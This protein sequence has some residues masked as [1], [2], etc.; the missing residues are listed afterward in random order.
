MATGRDTLRQ[1]AQFNPAA[2]TYTVHNSHVHCE[3]LLL[4]YLLLNPEIPPFNYFA[5]SKLCCYPCYALF[6]AY[7]RSV[8]PGEHKY[9]TKGCHNKI[10]HFW[11][12]P[13]LGDLKDSRIRSQLAQEH[14]ALELRV[15][16]KNR[17]SVRA[18]SDSTDASVSSTDPVCSVPGD[19]AEYG[20]LLLNM[21]DNEYF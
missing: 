17:Q 18:L 10:H 14:F 21:F 13:Q 19:A 5:V 12:L 15:L 2:G 6:H 3:G 4:R 20:T 11:P 1:S 9:F 8:G 16:L 7:N